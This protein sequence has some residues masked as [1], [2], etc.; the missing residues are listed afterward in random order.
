MRDDRLRDDPVFRH[1]VRARPPLNA[2]DL[3]PAGERATAI[4][5]RVL[6]ADA[7][8]SRARRASSPRVL[9]A[10]ALPLLG[11]AALVLLIAGVFSGPGGS[12]TQPALAAVIRRVEQATA[13]KPGTIVVSVVRTFSSAPG[14][15]PNPSVFE[16]VWET[17]AGPG[18]QNFMTAPSL[19][20]QLPGVPTAYGAI[21]GEQEIYVRK[22]NTVYISSIWGPYITKGKTPGTF[23]YSRPKFP[24]STSQDSAVWESL[25][26]KP[27]KLTP[28]QAHAVLDGSDEIE[29]G[30]SGD[31]RITPVPRIPSIDQG[32]RSL[33]SSRDLRIVGL[34]TVD[35]RRA[36]ELA[37]LR[38][39][40]DGGAQ[41]G[42]KFWVDPKTYAP[43]KRVIDSRAGH[44]TQ[45]WLE[46][47]TL[48]ITPAN[49]RLL[50]PIARYPHAHIDRNHNDYVNAAN[51]WVFPQ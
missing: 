6:G 25:P 4:L 32:L 40:R 20:K 51:G 28:A 23:I 38:S 26:A 39:S 8:A 27:L 41:A 22:T 44:V 37:G 48:P 49:K 33:L 35:G 18:P 13:V 45:T 3:S 14:P 43:I 31:S 9:F 1:V 10:A 2:E 7:P 30:N 16:Q 36:L 11:V 42:Q 5:E 21:D 24:G 50:S 15:G 17:P 19:T 46:Y 47:K 34:T 29:S 12:G